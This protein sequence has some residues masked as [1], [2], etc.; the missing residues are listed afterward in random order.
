[1]A[2]SSPIKRG[3]SLY[4]FQEEYF[5]GKMSL[6]DCIAAAADMGALG[7]ESIAEQM[8]PG[9]PKLSDE[10]Y[11]RWH[12]WMA[13]YGTVPTAHDMF[14]DTKLY[15]HR[16]LTEEEMLASVRRDIDH[17]ARLGCS[18]IRM[19]V[20][21]PPEVMEKSAAYAAERNVKLGLELHA[22][23]DWDHEWIQRHLEV[24]RRVDPKHLGI[25]LDMGVYAKRFPRVVADRAVR[26]GA[27]REIVDHIVA[28]YD[29]H[30]DLG[31]LVRDVETMG[32]N[33]L[34]LALAEQVT[35]WIYSD[36]A[37]LPEFIP[38]VFHVHAKFYEMTDEETEYS[39]PYEEVVPVLLEG[40]YSGYLSSEYE[41]NRHIQDVQEVDSVE[42]VRREQELFKALIGH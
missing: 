39:I 11:E 32:G 35:H 30:D 37:R 9:F 5:L 3:V 17:A 16:L 4:S 12:G 27:H 15:K 13:Q 10:F 21:T 41:G 8:M 42:Q 25:V 36:P 31:M 14:L 18:V 2:G 24:A 28:V 40:G 29:S 23:W 33:A 38:H 7:I 1:M 20:I 19:I 22:P 6:E 26:D 34:D